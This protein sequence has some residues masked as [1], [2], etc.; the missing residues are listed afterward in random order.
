M[1]LHAHGGGVAR[2]VRVHGAHY[3]RDGRLLVV[4]GRRVRHV[5]AQEDHRLVEHLRAEGF[6]LFHPTYEPG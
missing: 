5:H 1:L 3:G 2:G 4:A 6:T